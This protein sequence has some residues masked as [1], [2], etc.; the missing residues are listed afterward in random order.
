MSN[1]EWF[2]SFSQHVWRKYFALVAKQ[3][4]SIRPFI[5]DQAGRNILDTCGLILNTRFS[6][7]D[8][9]ILHM[10]YTSKWGDDLYAVEDY[11]LKHN[12]PTKTIWMVIRRANRLIA[13][14]TGFLSPKDKE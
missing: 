6:Q 7:T 4:E 13:E 9:D 12:I 11:S 8:Q 3:N 2:R 14:E 1:T 10:Y 5:T